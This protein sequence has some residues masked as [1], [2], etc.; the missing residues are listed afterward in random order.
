MSGD[1][2]STEAAPPDVRHLFEAYRGSLPPEGRPDLAGAFSFGDT[3]ALADTLADLVCVGEKTATAEAKW[4]VEAAGEPL[5][6]PGDHWVVLDGDGEPRCVIRT[7]RVE[8]V[9]FV[10]VTPDHAAAEGESDGS[11]ASWRLAHVRYY[12][13]TLPEGRSFDP[14]MPVVCERFRVVYRA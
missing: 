5:P 6:E 8:V 9:P 4:T 12:Q 7:E 2:L 1:D 3:P 10:D 13:R 11:L 14:E